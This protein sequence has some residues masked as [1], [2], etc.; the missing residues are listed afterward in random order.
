MAHKK[1]FP[2]HSMNCGLNDS[3]LK[4]YWL[5]QT[6]MTFNSSVINQRLLI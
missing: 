1:D 3:N 2:H 5:V 4:G 6:Q